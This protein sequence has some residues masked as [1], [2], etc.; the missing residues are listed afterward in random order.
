MSAHRFAIAVFLSLVAATS[1]QAGTLYK[2]ISPDGKVV[3]TD[4]PP[5]EHKIEQTFDSSTS[6][7]QTSAKTA[8]ASGPQSKTPAPA[9]ATGPVTLY[10]TSWC[11]YCRKARAYLNARGISF[12]EIDVETP[13]G[14]TAFAPVKGSGGVPVLTQGNRRIQGFSPQAYD[15]FFTGG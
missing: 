13:S 9:A 6:T 8:P 3:Y 11:P 14:K 15:Q 10:V 7:N 12:R 2:T 1:V 4:R 5:P